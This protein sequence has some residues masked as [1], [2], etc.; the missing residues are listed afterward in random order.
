MYMI[1]TATGMLAIPK[2]A[3]A[4][5]DMRTTAATGGVRTMIACVCSV[6]AMVPRNDGRV[7]LM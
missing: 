6:D 4:T 5:P 3:G 2:A 7:L 1:D